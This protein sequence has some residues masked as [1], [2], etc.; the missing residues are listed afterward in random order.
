M[1]TSTVKLGD[2]LMKVPMLDVAGT[3]WVIYKDC[4]LWCI[5]ARGLLEHVDSSAME[6]RYPVSQER[7]AAASVATPAAAAEAGDVPIE[8]EAE[9]LS[10]ADSLLMQEWRKELKVWKQGEAV[11]KQQI[12][13]SIPDSLFMKVRNEMTAFNIWKALS[14]IFQT[15]SR[16]VAVD[17]QRRLQME[18]CA[19]KGDVRAHFTKLRTMREDLAALG[20]TIPEDDF[21]TIVLGSLPSFYDSF[22]SSINGT[23][24]LLGTT[25]SAEDLMHGATQ[26][27]DLRNLRSKAGTSAKKEDNAAFFGLSG[28]GGKNSGGGSSKK[29]GKCHN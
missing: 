28:G 16:M 12:A 5:D 22:I 9:E 29:S 8:T 24:L 4:F 6:P 25:V 21:Y 17:L 11:V 7:V 14:A 15:K 26:E 23:A 10:T 18:R 2:S 3:N 19:E 1:S 27:F 20:Q 13:A